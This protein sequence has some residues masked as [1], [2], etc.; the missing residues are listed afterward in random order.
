ML[1]VCCVLC[2]VVMSLEQLIEEVRKYPCLWNK[3]KEEYRNQNVRDNAWESIA[4]FLAVEVLK[5]E[6]KKL[7]DCH[8]QAMLRRK[9]KSGDAARKIKPWKYEALMSFLL[10]DLTARE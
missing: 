1:I 3:S 6:W 5:Y 10:S 4:I 9:T 2:V 7:Q 8:R